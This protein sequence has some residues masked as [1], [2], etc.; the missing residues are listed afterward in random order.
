AVGRGSGLKVRPTRPP[1]RGGV[2]PRP[3]SGPGPRLFGFCGYPP[4]DL[5]ATWRRLLWRRMLPLTL[6]RP[7]FP[8][9]VLRLPRSAGSVG[10]IRYSQ[11]FPEEAGPVRV[12]FRDADHCVARPASGPGDDGS[13]RRET[14]CWV[15]REIVES[16]GEASRVGPVAGSG[17]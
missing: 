6:T 12:G 16:P 2:G 4:D 7:R 17:E 13:H 11:E 15:A 8:D 3:A 10:R 1:G 5:P 14:G 9:D